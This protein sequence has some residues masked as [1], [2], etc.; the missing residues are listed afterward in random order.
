[1][2]WDEFICSG[3]FQSARFGF[4]PEAP[5]IPVNGIRNAA[6]MEIF[7]LGSF[8]VGGTVTAGDVITLTIN[9][10]NYTYTVL[11]TDSLAT[12][13]IALANVINAGSGDP[14]VTA[15]YVPTLQIIELIARQPG[16]AGNNVTLNVS[17]S[18]TATIT[19]AA[20]G[21][22]LEGGENTSIVSAGTLIAIFGQNLADQAVSADFSQEMLPL[23]LGGVELYCDGNRSPLL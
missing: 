21:S 11:S 6:S 23:D 3:P 4:Y 10:T 2:G 19:L 7:A 8:T 13:S 14:N 17:A 18:D 15:T 9:G 1:M 20:S 5:L 16:E 12:I 22:T